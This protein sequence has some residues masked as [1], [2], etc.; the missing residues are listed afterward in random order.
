MGLRRAQSD[1]PCRNQDITY[2]LS[3]LTLALK[4]PNVE[5]VRG[6]N[7]AVKRSKA[8]SFARNAKDPLNLIRVMPA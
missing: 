4:R 1:A 3:G 2:R 5:H 8:E 6:A 7:L